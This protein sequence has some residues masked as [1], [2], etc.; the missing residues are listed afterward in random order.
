MGG[1]AGDDNQAD[2]GVLGSLLHFCKPGYGRLIGLG[3]VEQTRQ[4]S[5]SLEH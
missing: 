2:T 4:S 5:S 1:V 3:A